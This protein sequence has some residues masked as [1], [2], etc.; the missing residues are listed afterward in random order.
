MSY[1][2][3]VPTTEKYLDRPVFSVRAKKNGAELGKIGWY[4]PWNQMAFSPTPQT[5]WS[6]NC[7]RDVAKYME[8]ANFGLK[9]VKNK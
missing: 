7:L 5:I 2:E 4:K 3:V 6:N 8:Y 1:I 9:E